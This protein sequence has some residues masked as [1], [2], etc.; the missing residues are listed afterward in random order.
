MPN[1][2]QIIEK[3]LTEKGFSCQCRADG[4]AVDLSDYSK[5]DTPTRTIATG[6]R[7]MIEAQNLIKK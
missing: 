5:K 2:I 3:F 6:I 4:I 7:T 1:E